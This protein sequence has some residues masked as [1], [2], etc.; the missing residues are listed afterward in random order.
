MD[1]V[2]YIAAINIFGQRRASAS[3]PITDF[4][5]PL[6]IHEDVWIGP[7]QGDLGVA[8]LNACEPPGENYRRGRDYYVPYA[9]WRIYKDLAATSRFDF[10]P[11]NR[12]FAA[13]ALS[14]LVHPTTIGTY[15]SARVRMDNCRRIEPLRKP[16]RLN[17]WAF[18][19]D[20]DQDWL[21]PDDI[22]GLSKLVKSYFSATL[23]LRIKRALICLETSF[24]NY[25]V[26]Y[27][28]PLII[29]GFESLVRIK[30]EKIAGRKGK[31]VSVNS[32]RVFVDR[33]SA[34][35]MIDPVLALSRNDLEE[36]YDLRSDIVHG[37][38]FPDLDDERKRLFRCARGLLR[39]I[40]RKALLE[41]G[42]AAI[43]AKDED[44]RR[45][46]PL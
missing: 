19:I 43:F 44:I 29:T 7:L 27:S 38:G 17:P 23:P 28:W 1:V 10:D 13:V 36:I 12:L 18:P 35:G 21:I 11:D 40:L 34:L 41:P 25:Y 45:F 39:S 16:T 42:F 14:R 46:L 3:R 31:R 22:P 24:L 15:Y 5:Q 37:S 2:D 9:F 8:I 20:T 6:Q 33:L 4:I 26:E 30:D 32:K